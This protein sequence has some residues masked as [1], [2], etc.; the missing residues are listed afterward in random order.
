MLHEVWFLDVR[1]LPGLYIAP[2]CVTVVCLTVS[3]LLAYFDVHRLCIISIG[4]VCLCHTIY[5][6]DSSYFPSINMLMF[7]MAKRRV[8]IE[9]RVNILTVI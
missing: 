2:L 9:G 5:T 6:K 3:N 1:R 4:L 7:V 8:S